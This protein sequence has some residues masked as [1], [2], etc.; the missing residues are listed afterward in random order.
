MSVELGSAPESPVEV[1]EVV[2]VVATLPEASGAATLQAAVSE[3]VV[4]KP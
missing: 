4:L 1:F 3:V 2:E